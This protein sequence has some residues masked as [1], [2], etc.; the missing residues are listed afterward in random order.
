MAEAR[1]LLAQAHA[2][3]SEPEKQRM[4]AAFNRASPDF[5]FAYVQRACGIEPTH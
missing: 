4:V 3:Y 5:S 2:F 1:Q